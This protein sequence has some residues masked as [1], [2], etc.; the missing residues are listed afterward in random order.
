MNIKSFALRIVGA[1]GYAGAVQ[2]QRPGQWCAADRIAKNR[3]EVTRSISWRLALAGIA[4][5]IYLLLPPS[6]ALGA[7]NVWSEG[8][9]LQ[10]QSDIVPGAVSY[11]WTRH[12]PTNQ[13]LSCPYCEITYSTQ[14]EV[15]GVSS[16]PVF[17]FTGSLVSRPQAWFSVEAVGADDTVLTTIRYPEGAGMVASPGYG[18]PIPVPEGPISAWAGKP[19]PFLT[20]FDGGTATQ[21]RIISGGN[22]VAEGGPDVLRYQPPTTG[23]ISLTIEATN[24]CGSS[25]V[26]RTVNVVS[27]PAQPTS[28]L[29]PL[30]QQ[31]STTRI[32][33]AGVCVMAGHVTC[34]M[35]SVPLTSRTVAAEVAGVTW[36]SDRITVDAVANGSNSQVESRYILMEFNCT[37][38]TVV[39]LSGNY[40]VVSQVPCAAT[41][42]SSVTFDGVTVASG[43]QG[44]ISP[45]SVPLSTGQHWMAVE[46]HGGSTFV[47]SSNPC[48][49]ITWRHVGE[50]HLT[51][52]F[53]I[54]DNCPGDLDAN[55]IID[56]A[57]IGLLL[58]S[59]GFCGARCP[60]DLNN[61]GKVNGGDL[62]LLLSGWGNCPT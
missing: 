45:V 23:T 61:D 46:T 25:S 20:T 7:L 51:V 50:I 24:E 52:S 62:G 39:D 34:T 26:A 54:L 31:A 37:S 10:A 48:Y 38:D 42:W 29:F 14:S 41:R 2:T 58:S 49:P 53:D 56:G 28:P 19:M 43:E 11:R 9:R 32:W 35:E 33:N 8:C 30:S 57:D 47:S 59:W 4:M 18:A 15:L 1:V 13:T 22:V 5:P 44:P 17:E 12:Y 6:E 36:R 40:A 27:P 3:V 60:H 55:G 16:L 21:F